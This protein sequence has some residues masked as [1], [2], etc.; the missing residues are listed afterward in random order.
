MCASCGLTLPSRGRHKGCFAPFAPPLMSNVRTHMSRAKPFFFFLASIGLCFL[1]LRLFWSFPDCES[2]VVRKAVSPDN[3]H[4]ASVWIEQCNNRLEPELTLSISNR[5]T[6]ERRNSVS[7]G[8]ATTKNIEITWLSG[9][10]LQFSFPDSFTVAQQPSEIG[11]I[12]IRFH[13]TP[14]SNSSLHTGALHR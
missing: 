2:E 6:P 8:A 3:Q 1:L 10:H 7:I 11:G 5:A 12:E 9:R 14:S 4:E 13:P